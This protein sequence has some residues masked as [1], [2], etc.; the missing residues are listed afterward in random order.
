MYLGHYKDYNGYKNEQN[1]SAETDWTMLTV[2]HGVFRKTGLCGMKICMEQLLKW[3]MHDISVPYQLLADIK[4]ISIYC[5]W[6]ILGIYLCML[7]S[8]SFTIR[9]TF[10]SCKAHLKFT[11]TSK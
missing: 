1:D 4:D 10:S 5:Y 2:G 7:I 9:W 3:W 11:V 6:L 8:S